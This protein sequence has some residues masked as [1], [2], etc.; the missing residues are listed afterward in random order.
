MTDIK[1]GGVDVAD[2][3]TRQRRMAMLLWGSSGCGKTTLISTAPPKMLWVN[4]DPDGTSALGQRDDIVEFDFAPEPNRVVE[5]FRDETSAFFRD[6][7]KILVADEDREIQTVVFDSLTSF[8][9]KAFIHGVKVA[10]GTRKGRLS[11]LEEPGYSGWG[12]VNIWTRLL[13]THGLVI[14]LRHNRHVVFI[15]HEDKP[16]YSDDGMLL[17]ISIMLGSS[18]NEQVPVSLNEVWHM[19]AVGKTGERRLQIR[20]CRSYKPM[21]TRMFKTSGEPEFTWKFDVDNWKGEGIETWYNQW[22]KNGFA[23]IALPS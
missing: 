10:Q 6:L 8:R 4:F 15:A 21:K 2:T 14:T 18:L 11:T 5:K 13:V 19:E 12:N 23:K 20:P 22:K 1:L 7:D 3:A 16:T 9:D 17:Y